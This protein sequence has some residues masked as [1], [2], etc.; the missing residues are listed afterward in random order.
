M[1]EESNQ[2]LERVDTVTSTLIGV[3]NY[4]KDLS[5][6]QLK[7]VRRLCIDLYALY[8]FLWHHGKVLK[9]FLVAS[10]RFSVGVDHRL[11]T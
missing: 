6:A 2:K 9:W 8:R 7:D 5:N 10:L 3:I 1:F 11:A 4:L